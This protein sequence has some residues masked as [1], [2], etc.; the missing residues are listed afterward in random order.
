VVGV[1]PLK[2]LRGHVIAPRVGDPTKLLHPLEVSKLPQLLQNEPTVLF[3]EAGKK[4]EPAQ[5]K[6][7]RQGTVIVILP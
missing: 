2:D 3:L 1:I 6:D 7:V 5:L 4:L